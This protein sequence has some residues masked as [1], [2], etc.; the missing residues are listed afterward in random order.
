MA[1]VRLDFPPGYY[2]RARRSSLEL[3][4]TGF[5]LIADG[6]DDEI[7]AIFAAQEHDETIKAEER[8]AVENAA[9]HAAAD[10]RRAA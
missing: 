9:E 6:F 8:E 5:G 7:D 1:G 3:H 2:V 4:L 10:L